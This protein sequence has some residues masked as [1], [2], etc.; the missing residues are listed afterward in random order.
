[1]IVWVVGEPC[2][3]KTTLVRAML[4]APLKLHCYQGLRWTVAGASGRVAA[5]GHHGRQPSP[6]DGATG[7]HVRKY[8][9]MIRND[10]ILEERGLLLLDGC[11][12]DRPAAL[13]TFAMSRDRRCVFLEGADVAKERRE[14]L[15]RDGLTEAALADQQRGNAA[16]LYANFP[17]VTLR[18]AADLPPEVLAAQV[19]EFLGL[20]RAYLGA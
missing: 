8:A 18:V 3:G 20:D 13:R 9:A 6:R 7:P 17:G 5:T 14:A 1:M 19:Y 2:V 16:L 11:P 15:G 10:L 4:P 12:F